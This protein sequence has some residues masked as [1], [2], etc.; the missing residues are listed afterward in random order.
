MDPVHRQIAALRFR[1]QQAAGEVHEPAFAQGFDVLARD[2][3]GLGPIVL[4]RREIS[5]CQHRERRGIRIDR[6]VVRS[7]TEAEGLMVPLS[8]LVKARGP[9]PSSSPLSLGLGKAGFGSRMRF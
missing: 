4:N 2:L 9:P 6:A 1:R 7:P 8:Y 3:E 5:A